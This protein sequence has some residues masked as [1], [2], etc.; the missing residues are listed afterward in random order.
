M[1]YL[2]VP[3]ARPCSTKTRTGC[4]PDKVIKTRPIKY[5]RPY[6]RILIHSTS[7]DNYGSMRRHL[8]DYGWATCVAT[9]VSKKKS[10][11]F[12][13]RKLESK[14]ATLKESVII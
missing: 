10:L 14:I 12:Y 9:I 3:K 11:S 2:V 4:L 13:F 5:K 8:D 7:L 1:I 6:Y